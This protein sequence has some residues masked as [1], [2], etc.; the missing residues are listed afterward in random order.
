MLMI[1]IG[2]ER[3]LLR[4]TLGHAEEE[5]KELLERAESDLILS[6]RELHIMLDAIP[7]PLSWAII[8]G[9][10]IQLVNRAFRKT[11]GY[12]DGHFQSVD[13]WIDETYIRESDRTLSRARWYELWTKQDSGIS[14]I[15]TIEIQVRCA[16]G[17]ILTVRHKGILLHDISIGIATF[18][19]ITALKLVEE[20]LHRIAFEDPLTGLPNRRAL[21]ARWMQE[22]EHGH[23]GR[24]PFLA[25]LLLDLDGFKT[26]NDQF[27]HDV[28]DETLV[29]VGARLQASIRSNDLACR[30]GGD[31]FLVLLSGLNTPEVAETVCQ[32][33]WE[34]FQSPLP[35]SDRNV[36]IG[37]SIGMSL[38]PTHSSELSDLMK[39]ADLAL[40]A[41]KKQHKG[42]WGWFEPQTT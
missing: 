20:A 18:E 29:A 36:Q 34:A 22:M 28:G 33:I 27:G 37:V 8:P 19:D 9:G 15:D 38:Y 4:I 32:R 39:Q 12:P 41:V 31:E 14:E 40:Y 17:S 35:L 24:P 10:E 5:L 1:M 30:L 25:L 16:D 7:V 6:K 26:I 2:H 21:Q 13:Q 23:I 42:G 11:F 3:S